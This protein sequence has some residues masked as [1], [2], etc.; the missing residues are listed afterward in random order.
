MCLLLSML[1]LAASTV[2]VRAAYAEESQTVTEPDDGGAARTLSAACGLMEDGQAADSD[3]TAAYAAELMRLNEGL[4]SWTSRQ[5]YLTRQQRLEA[6]FD[7]ANRAANRAL[8]IDLTD[9]LEGIQPFDT[10]V[11]SEF[12]AHAEAFRTL[13]E[14]M[15]NA[16]Q[17]AANACMPTL[18]RDM[19]T[20]DIPLFASARTQFGFTWKQWAALFRAFGLDLPLAAAKTVQ[21]RCEGSADGGVTIEW[22]VPTFDELAACGTRDELME[23]KF[24]LAYLNTIYD[25]DGNY[26]PAETP[27]LSESYLST[28]AHPLPGM[29]IKNGWLDPRSDHTRLHTGT[30]ILAPARTPILSATDGV[31]L[32]IGYMAIPGNYVVIEDP[33]GYE[34]HYYHMNEISTFVHEGETVEQGQV[35]GRVGSTGNSAAYHLHLA[36]ISPDDVYLNPYDLFVQAGIGPIRSD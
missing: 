8:E 35:I 34:Y 15:E 33:Y 25:D 31:V 5:G 16:L 29:T 11:Y 10:G 7:A 12:A 23:A 26:A 14:R 13:G 21:T 3:A 36:V 17:S 6:A 24:A 20:L 18:S 22:T 9:W 4:I 1:L 30:D 19:R 28:I 27:V 32:Y 2:S